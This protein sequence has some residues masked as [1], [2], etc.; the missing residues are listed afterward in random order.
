MIAHLIN[1]LRTEKNLSKNLGR[2]KMGIVA[3]VRT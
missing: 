3:A 1:R 2:A